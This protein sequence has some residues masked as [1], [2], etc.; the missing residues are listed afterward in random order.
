MQYKLRGGHGRIVGHVEYYKLQLMALAMRYLSWKLMAKESTILAD[1]QARRALHAFT[2][3]VEVILTF[4]S[5]RA[6]QIDQRPL[7]SFQEKYEPLVPVGGQRDT[8]TASQSAL[9]GFNPPSRS[10][11]E[12]FPV[13][14]LAPRP[15]QPVYQPPTPPPEEDI[16]ASSMEWTP[17]HKFQPPITYRAS[18]TKPVFNEPSPFHG[19]L[20]PAPV[21]WAQRLRNP[22]NQ[23]SFHKASQEKKENFF[24]KKSSRV[25]SD[26]A[27]D[28]SSVA[29][30]VADSSMFDFDSPVKFAPP[31][32]F[33]PAD[34]METGLESLFSDT[35]SLGREPSV[36]EQQGPPILRTSAST[37]PL[38]RL[39]TALLLAASC[40][41]WDYASAMAPVS[42]K[43]LRLTSIAVAA[44][45]LAY[46]FICTARLPQADRSNVN[47][48]LLGVGFVLAT[49]IGGRIREY[50]E[51]EQRQRQSITLGFW[52]LVALT[53]QEAWAFI[54][55][56][57][58]PPPETPAVA[59][60]PFEPPMEQIP[61]PSLETQAASKPR[62][63]AGNNNNKRPA[64]NKQT[65]SALSMQAKS[66]HVEISQRTTRSKARNEA[67][68]NSIGDGLGSLSLGGW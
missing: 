68:R 43:T 41:A 38:P 30:S 51:N 31:R 32:F 50:S 16:Q 9:G 52:Y 34:R 15:Y 22:P 26:A 10:R 45:I 37:N 61:T 19:V 12:H 65:S 47:L 44:I 13:E 24:G 49:Y 4:L 63:A 66:N 55:S 3:V 2:L 11:V 7:V 46:N 17:Q 28:V 18:Q 36:A 20:P 14:K 39:L 48:S 21:S 5:F 53:I 23:P 59:E 67:R 8:N 56:L 54:S 1:P 6:I 27:S 62:K 40:V 58:A 35:F 64:A 57:A 33:A 42:G 25:I 60:T 29:P